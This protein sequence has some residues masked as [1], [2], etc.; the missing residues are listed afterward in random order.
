MCSL[1]SAKAIFT[2]YVT[3]EEKAALY[4]KAL[5]LAFPSL[6]EGFGLPVLEAMSCGC[7][8]LTANVSSLPEVAGH[9]AL[10]V[11]PLDVK[12]IARGLGE[13]VS[14]PQLRQDLIKKGFAQVKKFSWVK[15]AQQT[16][17][18]YQKVVKDKK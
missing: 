17:A 5:C 18:V 3:Q 16:L 6:Y 4:T 14:N 8:V 1:N 10:L 11:D 12:E 9:A 2:G 13:M 15:A 7:P